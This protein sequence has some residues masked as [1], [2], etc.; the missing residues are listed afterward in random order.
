M[1]WYKKYGLDF[2]DS[3][4]DREDPD[5]DG[6]SNVVE[7]RNDPVGV[8]HKT[9]ECDPHKSSDPSDGKSHPDYLARL[10]LQKYET[11]P[12]HILFNGYQ[13]LNGVYVFQLHLNDVE[14]DKQ[15][16]LLKTGDNLG[17][18]GYVIGS[19]HQEFQDVVDD[20]TKVKVRTDVSTLELD[21]ARHQP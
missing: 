17:F 19:F 2:T 6:F 3:N 15:P 12:F 5:G 9:S 13:Q 11:R 20:A 14:S 4:V 7:F 8:R 10:R 21:Q 1:W 18:E 16:P